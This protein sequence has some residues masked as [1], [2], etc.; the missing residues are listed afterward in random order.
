MRIALSASEVLA[1]ALQ[2]N[3]RGLV[4][5]HKTFGKGLVQSVLGLPNGAGLTLT[6]ARYYTPS[7]RS[8]QRD[9]SHVGLYDY[10]NHRNPVEIGRPTYASKTITNRTVYGGDGITPD[11]MSNRHPVNPTQIELLDP[12]F[13]FVREYANGRINIRDEADQSQLQQLRRKIV[14]GEEMIPQSLIDRFAEFVAAERSWK[15][16]IDSLNRERHIYFRHAS[17]QPCNGGIRSRIRE[18]VKDRG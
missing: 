1:G 4:I 18:Q 14:F 8:I 13:F 16:D 11:E 10:F 6:A 15:I 3:D 17:I 12:L 5:G 9:Y 7:G 2:D